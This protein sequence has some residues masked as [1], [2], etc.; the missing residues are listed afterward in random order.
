[1]FHPGGN[2]AI[3]AVFTGLCLAALGCA[4]EG[5]SPPVNEDY[6]ELLTV[7][8]DNYREMLDGDPSRTVKT[9]QI[10]SG[11]E[12]IA[13][14][15]E[16]AREDLLVERRDPSQIGEILVALQQSVPHENA[17]CNFSGPSWTLVAYDADLFRVGVVR[18]SPC[19]DVEGNLIGVVPIGNVAIGYSREAVGVL[20]A[21]G[22]EVPNQ[23]PHP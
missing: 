2:S 18:L 4:D 20:K 13:C 12:A 3:L 14:L 16:I 22:I 6:S 23:Q 21:V 1:M 15:S 8:S 17:T 7:F 10:Y 5:C 19:S 9:V 11:G